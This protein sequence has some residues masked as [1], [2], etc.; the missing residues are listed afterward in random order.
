MGR[1]KKDSAGV[2]KTVVRLKRLHFWATLAFAVQIPPAMT[3]WK[4]SIPYLVGI[5][6]WANFASHFAAWQQ[7]RQEEKQDMA[8]AERKEEDD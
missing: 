3:I 2:D 8:D 7:T 5:S 1:P 6:V 4:D